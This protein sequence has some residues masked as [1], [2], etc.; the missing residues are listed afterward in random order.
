MIARAEQGQIS[1]NRVTF[2]IEPLLLEIV[3]DFRLLA[4]D[5]GRDSRLFVPGGRLR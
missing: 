2:D 4:D 3:D 1:L 5:E